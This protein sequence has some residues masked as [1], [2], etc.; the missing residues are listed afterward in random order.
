MVYPVGYAE[1]PHQR[2]KPD[3]SGCDEDGRAASGALKHPAKPAQEIVHP[4]GA[5]FIAEQFGQEYRQFVDDDEHGLVV[6]GADIEELSPPVPPVSPSEPGPDLQAERESAHLVDL[7]GLVAKPV[8]HLAGE[9]RQDRACW[10][11][12]SCEAGDHVPLAGCPFDIGEEE[13]PSLRLQPPAEL[14]G[15]ARLAHA[16]LSGQQHVIAVADPRF[17]HP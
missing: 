4:S 12:R 1:P 6:S 5:I 9:A 11:E 3:A 13:D 16:P 2:C 8:L 10:L 7:F 17:Q 15:D 14:S